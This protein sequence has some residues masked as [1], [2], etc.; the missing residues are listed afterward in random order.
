MTNHSALVESR[1]KQ[2]DEEEMSR[3]VRVLL[4]KANENPRDALV[5]ITRY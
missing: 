4:N 2:M 3:Y 5:T 1:I